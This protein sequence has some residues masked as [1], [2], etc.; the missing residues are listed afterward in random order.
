LVHKNEDLKGGVGRRDSDEVGSKG[1][2]VWV[3]CI[4]SL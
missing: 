1:R 3:R 2:L 4:V